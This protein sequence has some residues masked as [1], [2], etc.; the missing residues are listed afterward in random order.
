M[1]LPNNSLVSQPGFLA[2]YDWKAPRARARAPTISAS[3]MPP[4][5][6]PNGDTTAKVALSALAAALPI[7]AAAARRDPN[8]GRYAVSV[9]RLG[10]ALLIASSPSI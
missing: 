7:L 8:P 2:D 6:T 9:T 1:R 3:R 4:S 10:S 5:M